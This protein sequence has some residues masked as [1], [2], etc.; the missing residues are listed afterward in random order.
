MIDNC[1]PGDTSS[2]RVC[3]VFFHYCCLLLLFF[4]HF[5]PAK[6]KHLDT[7]T[8][9]SKHR[10]SMMLTVHLTL[11]TLASSSARR[12][13]LSG[14]F[15]SF[16]ATLGLSITFGNHARANGTDIGDRERHAH[17]SQWP[18]CIY[19]IYMVSLLWP[20]GLGGTDGGPCAAPCTPEQLNETVGPGLTLIPQ[21]RSA[22]YCTVCSAWNSSYSLANCFHYCFIAPHRSAEPNTQRNM[23]HFSHWNFNSQKYLSRSGPL[24]SR[25][26]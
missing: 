13:P 19:N 5:L 22:H 12:N 2:Q 14:D 4:T 25:S 9:S 18:T 16:L 7:Q 6:H 21:R 11:S 15:S 24:A 20:L 1:R 8:Y 23:Q 17:D 3:F 26:I 10:N